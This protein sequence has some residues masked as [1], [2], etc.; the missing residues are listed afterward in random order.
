LRYYYYDTRGAEGDSAEPGGA[1]VD[2]TY[3]VLRPRDSANIINN[4]SSSPSIL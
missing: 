2:A 3:N 1:T 4:N